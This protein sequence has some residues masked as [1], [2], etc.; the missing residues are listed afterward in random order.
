MSNNSL[1]VLQTQA[2]AGLN[3]LRFLAL[4]SN[5]LHF[6]LAET[7]NNMPE[8]AFLTLYHQNEARC[9]QID[10]NYDLSQLYYVDFDLPDEEA[11]EERILFVNQLQI[12]Q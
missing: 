12:P 3:N 11:I 6:I 10:S 1:D 2:F 8:I 9:V 4:S 7:L 5:N